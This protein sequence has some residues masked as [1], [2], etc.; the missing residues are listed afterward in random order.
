ML[1]YYFNNYK[2]IW[3]CTVSQIEDVQLY[4]NPKFEERLVSFCRSLSSRSTGMSEGFTTEPGEDGSTILHLAAALGYT[5]LTT[6][7]LRWK[8]DDNS[9]ALEKEVNLGARD[10][11][12]CTPLVS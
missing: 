5:K 6:V 2:T 1:E 8:Q 12:N 10:V 9:L 11:D 7:L 3:L 4:S